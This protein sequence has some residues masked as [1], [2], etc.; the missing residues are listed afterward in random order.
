MTTF[1]ILFAPTFIHRSIHNSHFFSLFNITSRPRLPNKL[2]YTNMLLMSSYVRDK[3]RNKLK[4]TKAGLH[5]SVP[6]SS[7]SSKG[8]IIAAS[9]ILLSLLAFSPTCHARLQ[10]DNLE[11]GDQST[12][13]VLK[14]AEVSPFMLH[15]NCQTCRE[16]LSQRNTGKRKKNDNSPQLPF[17]PSSSCSSYSKFDAKPKKECLWWKTTRVTLLEKWYQNLQHLFGHD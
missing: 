14:H 3:R 4:D 5:R 12:A 7:L 10:K 17:F 6:G 9:F 15:D 1:T 8:I 16:C 2:P 11:Q 13:T